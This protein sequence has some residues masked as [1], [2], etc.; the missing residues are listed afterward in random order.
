MKLI[1][2]LIN[3]KVGQLEITHKGTAE[4]YFIT[5]S[6]I[7]N[8]SS[9]RN[10]GSCLRQIFSGFK[11]PM[12]ISLT[13]IK[14]VLYKQKSWSIYRTYRFRFSEPKSLFVKTLHRPGNIAVSCK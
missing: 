8:N 10:I 9:T 3:M 4:I 14:L 5:H 13:I 1:Q 2:N 6:E 11:N 12:Y 7:Q